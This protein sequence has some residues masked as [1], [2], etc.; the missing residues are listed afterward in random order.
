MVSMINLDTLKV[1][2][3]SNVTFF[4][5]DGFWVKQIFDGL[6]IINYE[7][8]DGVYWDVNLVI[9]FPYRLYMITERSKNYIIDKDIQDTSTLHLDYD[10]INVVEICT[11]W[12]VMSTFGS[13]TIS[14]E[15]IPVVP[16][17]GPTGNL[18]YMNYTYN[19][20]TTH[21]VIALDDDIDTMV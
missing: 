3:N 2:N 19:T 5:M 21:D 1:D 6:M 11:H 20:D 14:S 9:P 18:V 10:S 17:D 15:L 8:S 7:D 13:V 12:L 4:E 16:M